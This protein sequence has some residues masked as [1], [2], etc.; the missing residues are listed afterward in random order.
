M[1]YS[2]FLVITSNILFKVQSSLLEYI[3]Y[4]NQIHIHT[5]LH[6]AS[7]TRTHNYKGPNPF[8][9]FFYM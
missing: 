5:T 3:L 9:D 7:I 1:K 6:T 4:A 8:G 2:T